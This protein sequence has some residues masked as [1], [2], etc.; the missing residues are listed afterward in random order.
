MELK[1]SIVNGVGMEL[2]CGVCF[3]LDG[4]VFLRRSQVHDQNLRREQ[5]LGAG[6]VAIVGGV[7]QLLESVPVCKSSGVEF[8][9]LLSCGGSG[10]G[11]WCLGACC[12]GKLVP[13]V[14]LSRA[15]PSL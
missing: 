1:L 13:C 15:Q 8:P 3:V 7:E 10:L 9:N 12:S 4:W 2:E 11:G 6:K 14:R 5:Q